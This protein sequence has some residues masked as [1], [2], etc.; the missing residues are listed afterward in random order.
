VRRESWPAQRFAWADASRVACA[1]TPGAGATIRRE[2][3]TTKSL[4]VLNFVLYQTG[5]FATVLG[6]AWQR[7]W[8]GMSFAMALLAVHVVLTT[9]RRQEVR[10]IVL[11]VLVGLVVDTIQV[12]AGSFRFASGV[13]VT[14]LPP[15]WM[16][17]MWAQFATTLRYCLLWLSGRYVL[18]AVM[19]LFGGPLA[20]FAGERLGAI[21]ILAPRGPRFV[22]LGV[23]WMASLPLLVRAA[24]RFQQGRARPG[25]YRPR[26]EW[27]LE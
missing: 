1:S 18:S 21:T 17:V 26:K 20:F 25:R 15:P 22:L 27:R 4:H 5:W 11:A 10:Q 12:W 14:W 24:D 3:S 16:A 19:G 9:N 7:P 8:L 6:A 23:L 2:P 13:I